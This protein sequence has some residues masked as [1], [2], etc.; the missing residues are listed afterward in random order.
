MKIHFWGTRG[1]I[2]TPLTPQLLKS[3]ISSILQRIQPS[4]L[5]SPESKE[6]FLAGLPPEIFGHVGGNTTC[7]QVEDNGEDII[8]DAGTGIRELGNEYIL[9]YPEGKVYHLLLTH[10]HWDHIQGLPFFQPLFSSNNTIYFYSP[11]PGFEIFLREQMRE[12]YFPV[13][14]SVFSAKI[15]FIE[16]KSSSFAI[17]RISIQWRFVNHPGNC[18]SYRFDNGQKKFVFSTDTELRVS[19]FVKTEENL[20]FYSG[21]DCLVMDAQY[22][23]GESF[24]KTNWGHT[25][26]SLDVDF[27]HDYGIKK[28]VLFHHE[29]NYNDQKVE[30][31]GRLAQWY[32]DHKKKG[33]LKVTLAREGYTENL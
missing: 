16:L 26:Y 17:G 31:I 32:S 7:V 18:V 10:F 30:E 1:S 21:I 5:L 15:H 27:A 11:I 3:K 6:L 33:I 19:D 12:P 14:F 8:I 22:T 29:P 23:L 28:L 9:D 4:D 20:K 25:S 24:E 2:P 13:S